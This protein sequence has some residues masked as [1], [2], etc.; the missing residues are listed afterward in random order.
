MGRFSGCRR[1]NREFRLPV[2]NPTRMP[3]R[4]LDIA[5][6]PTTGKMNIPNMEVER[7]DEH[8]DQ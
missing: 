7:D 6:E 3:N 2:S 4:R 8:R 5:D 1:A